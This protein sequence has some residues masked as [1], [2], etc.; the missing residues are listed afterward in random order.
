MKRCLLLSIIIILLLPPGRPASGQDQPKLIG[1]IEFFGYSGIDLDKI[2]AELPFQEKERFVGE[3]FAEKLE[4]AREAVKSVTGRWPT[5]I[6]NTCCDS[7]GNWIIFIGLSGKI[8]HYAPHPRGTIR[9][10]EKILD[11]YERFMTLNMESV[12]KGR[13]A[14]DQS[15]GYALSEYPPLRSA[16]LE[17]RAYAVT[18]GA[19]LRSVLEGSRE[20]RERIA[21]AELLGFS[22]QSDAQLASL[23]RATRDGNS[24]VR[25]NATR[26]LFVLAMS[27]SK[28]ATRIPVAGFIELLLSGTWT[29]LNKSSNLLAIITESRDRKVLAQLHRKEVLERLIE[30]ARWRSHGVP[31]AMILGRIAGIDEGRLRQLITEGEVEIVIRELQDRLGQRSL[32]SLPADSYIRSLWP[33]SESFDVISGRRRPSSFNSRN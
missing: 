17:M 3:T 2:R 21:A 31:A 30:M 14:E 5:E 32:S 29:D 11:L 24:T 16:Q 19:L 28:I 22:R 1:E 9:L 12:Q 33:R 13:F 26:A 18:H 7:Q 10:P 15:K 6:S 4:R 20:D 27:K 8:I 25:N 23:I